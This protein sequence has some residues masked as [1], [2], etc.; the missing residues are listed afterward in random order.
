MP[1]KKCTGKSLGKVQMRS[2]KSYSSKKT[3]EKQVKD[4]DDTCNAINCASIKK[5]AKLNF[6]NQFEA[7]LYL[8]TCFKRSTPVL[9]II[10]A[11]EMED[12]D[13]NDAKNNRSHHPLHFVR[14][15]Y[16]SSGAKQPS[17]S[18]RESS[19]RFLEDKLRSFRSSVWRIETKRE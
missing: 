18:E 6:K 5:Q 9:L 8:K 19:G 17:R 1:K 2:I 11:V 4:S 13:A 15:R 10:S 7:A 3:C 12:D 14:P 16:S